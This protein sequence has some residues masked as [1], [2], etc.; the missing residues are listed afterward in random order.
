MKT[1]YATQGQSHTHR[2][3]GVTVDCDSLVAIEA[4]DY[5]TAYAYANEIF[6]NKWCSLYEEP[7]LEY[8]PRGVVLTLTAHKPTAEPAK[9]QQ[10]EIKDIIL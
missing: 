7:D 5:G 8:Y 1:F 10:E 3:Q 4:E 9:E 2:I 6:N